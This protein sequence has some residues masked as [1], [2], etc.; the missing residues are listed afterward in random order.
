M[1]KVDSVYRETAFE[2]TV[3]GRVPKD[4]RIANLVD[5]GK[6]VTGFGFPLDYQGK[7][8]GKYPFVKV[9]DMNS[10]RKYVTSAHNFVD[11]DDLRLLKA[12]AFPPNTIIFPKI[13]MALYLNKF[14]MLKAWATFD[15]NVAGVIPKGADP[16]FLFYYFVGRVDLRQLSG[17][18]TAPSIRKSTLES[19]LVP[20]PSSLEQKKIADILRMAD[21]AIEQTEQIIVNTERLKQGLMQQLLTKG[22][23]HKEFKDSEI[24]RI[25]KEW[26]VVTIKTLGEV[27]TGTTPS[28]SEKSY[29]NGEVP[30][31]TPTDFSENNYVDE[32]ERKVTR[33]GAERGRLIP[34][35]SVLVV[36]I[37]STIGKIALSFTK[38]I[39]NQQINAIVCRDG[40]NPHYV[41][42]GLA[43]RKGM[44]RAQA[45]ITA[46]PIVNK[47]LFEKFT[48]PLPPSTSEQKKIGSILSTVARKLELE[49]NEKAKLERTKLALMDLLLTGKIRIKVD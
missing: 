31:V 35:D 49:R 2:D 8:S 12:E 46:K 7:K 33:K 27:I 30:F 1:M 6:V 40:V 43:Q 36:C 18:T 13:G 20:F 44:L 22:I 11:D 42:Y 26:N 17:R 9:G 19:I 45:G 37:G 21:E 10:T 28:T 14:R 4:W 25:P 3:I 48:L 23:G 29:W 5:V 16:E 41:Y 34:K 15:N 32:T 38:C 47:S 24:G 39:T